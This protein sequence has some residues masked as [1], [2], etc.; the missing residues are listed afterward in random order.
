MILLSRLIKGVPPLVNQVSNDKKVISI[1]VFKP[2][3]IEDDFEPSP[4]RI[5]EHAQSII[6]NAE[7][8]AEEIIM[9]ARQEAEVFRQHLD[10]ERQAFELEK[11][12][13]AAEAHESGFASGYEEGQQKGY[14]EYHN[15]IQS[16]QSI[17]NSAKIDYREHVES[18]EREILEIGI[19]VAQKILGKTIE[20]NEEEFLSIVKGALKEARENQE[21]Q[22]HVNPAHFE[23]I[24]ANKADLKMLFPKEVDIFVYPDDQLTESSCVIE[25]VNGRIDA[26]IDSQLEEIKRKLIE[27]LEGEQE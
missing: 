5:D 27:L 2:E 1:K 18:S 21:V 14:L 12:R 8:T 26:S 9:G 23:F 7:K 24:L 11:E 25:S 13:M 22:L 16:A 20:K 4:I 3:L 6:A 19:K 15:V 17:V 10:K